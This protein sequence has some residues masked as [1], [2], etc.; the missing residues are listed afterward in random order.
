MIFFALSSARLSG[1]K[2]KGFVM[3]YTCFDMCEKNQSGSH[4]IDYGHCLWCNVKCDCI[5]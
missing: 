3:T 5:L 1:K 2:K 4:Y